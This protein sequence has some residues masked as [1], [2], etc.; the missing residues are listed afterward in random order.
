MFKIIR[1]LIKKE[2]GNAAV[3]MTAAM[4]GLLLMTGLVIDGGNLYRIKSHLQKT[5]NAAALSGAQEIPA[6]A[7]V[8]QS[9]V[10]EVLEAH[11]E[12]E[13]LQ[14]SIVENGKTLSVQLEKEVPLFFASLFGVKSIPVAA[15]AKAGIAPIASAEG[16]VPLGID[17][18]VPLVYGEK[19]QLKVDAGDSVSGNFGVLALAGPGAKS[20]SETLKYG[21]DEE[22]AVGDIVKTETGNIAGP[23]SEGVNLRIR[24]CPAVDIE[25]I[26]RDCSRVM[27]VLVYQPY[28]KSTNQLKSVKITGFAYFYITDP[29]GKNDSSIQ[30]IFI[31][32][33]GRGTADPEN[34]LDR[35]AFAVRLMKR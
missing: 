28:E 23:T 34:T 11:Q 5:A 29:M 9:I 7:A 19:Y 8:V 35:G 26:D 13:S 12:T 17:D 6:D 33:T 3:L 20:Y 32:K 15:S 1:S 25:N 4:A 10:Q 16:A 2:T 31:K 18:R 21:F 30:G 22:L 14:Q 24:Q 27:L